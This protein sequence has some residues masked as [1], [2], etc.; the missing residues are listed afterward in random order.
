MSD[1]HSRQIEAGVAMT[2]SVA[3]LVKQYLEEDDVDEME[4][5]TIRLQ[6]VMEG[7]IKEDKSFQDGIKVLSNMRARLVLLCGKLVLYPIGSH[8]RRLIMDPE[9]RE[10]R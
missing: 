4:K 9:K 1:I 7:Y 3:R 2:I 8:P 5:A 6:K 10:H